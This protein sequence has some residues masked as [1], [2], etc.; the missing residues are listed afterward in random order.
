MLSPLTLALSSPCVI[1]LATSANLWQL[2]PYFDGEAD[3][4]K[5]EV[6]YRE[7]G[8]LPRRD[9]HTGDGVILVDTGGRVVWWSAP[10]E[11]AVERLALPWS[12][13]MRCC[14]ALGCADDEAGCLTA[15]ALATADG[16]ESRP[17]RS[18]AL[19]GTVTARTIR[20]GVQEMVAFE[21]RFRNVAG[22]TAQTARDVCVAALGRLSVQLNGQSR[23]G[24]WLQQRPGQVFRYLL[25]SR[26][27]AQ[28]SE[29]IASA[30]WPERGPSAVANVR[31]CIF[32]LREQLG[33]RGEP[34]DSLVARDAAG[35]RI[36]LDRV[37]LDVDAF[38]A[39]SV[40]GI[41][42]H[43]RGEP[44]QAEA[45]LREALG[46]YRGEF[47]ADDPYADWALSEREYLRALAGKDLAAMAQI[48]V[49]AGR[50][51]GA[52]EHLL[53]LSQLEP[54]DSHV[55]QM[56]IEVCLRRG[57]RT[58]ALRHYDALRA[59]LHRAFGEL[60]DFELAG[61]ACR[62]REAPA[63]TP[64]PPRPGLALDSP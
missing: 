13:G 1:K 61:L 56:L 34:A 58:E 26:E 5:V 41:A 50:L 47:L 62:Q 20:S 39:K 17:W 38:Q 6:T 16:L 36:D 12:R 30:L 53:R 40:A 10:M 43:R 23:D 33:E 44:A 3:D 35:Y 2:R 18:G 19:E 59:R 57:R 11:A 24:D 55:H 48:A 22:G 25:A 46:L 15:Q 37:E 45:L 28:R 60:P 4:R 14:E 31:Y 29:A 42:A 27:S 8:L 49:A 54:F 64:P 9:R 51:V 63:R 7:E 32:K 21:L 52:T